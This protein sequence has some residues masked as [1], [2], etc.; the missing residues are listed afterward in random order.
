MR[1]V[2]GE[3]RDRRAPEGI[4]KRAAAKAFRGDVDELELAGREP[5]NARL[6]F[7]E[8]ERTINEGGRNAAPFQRI[9]LILHQ[10]D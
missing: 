7:R 4:E 5:A 10:G 1:L 3:Q 6:L 9:D 2:D 8:R